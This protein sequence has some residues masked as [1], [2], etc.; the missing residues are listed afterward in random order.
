MFGRF[1]YRVSYLLLRKKHFGIG[2]TEFDFIVHDKMWREDQNRVLKLICTRITVTQLFILFQENKALIYKGLIKPVIEYG[3]SIWG[4]KMGRK[5]EQKHK[6]VI[7]I[8]NCKTQHQH[9]EPLMVKLNILK[10]P[11]LYKQRTCVMLH[12]I[13]HKNVPEIIQ[14]YCEWNSTESRRWHQIKTENN[15]LKMTKK[16]PKFTQINAL[17][18]SKV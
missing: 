18:S 17:P 7:R 11:D 14:D 13:K 2:R 6:R 16:L 9:T 5:L 1:N 8:L 3:L 12:K 15:S 4:H 10:L